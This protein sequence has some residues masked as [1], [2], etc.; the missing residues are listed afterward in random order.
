[1]GDL[2]GVG[3]ITLCPIDEDYPRQL[4]PS[5]YENWGDAAAAANQMLIDRWCVKLAANGKPAIDAG[6]LSA[7]T[8]WYGPSVA[9]KA[10]N[11]GISFIAEYRSLGIGTMS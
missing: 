1:M 9:S 7:H 6:Y 10:M 8:V 5:P 2:Q 3:E 4:I 11:I